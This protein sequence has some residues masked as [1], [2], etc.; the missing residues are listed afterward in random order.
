MVQSISLNDI[1][2]AITGIRKS[3]KRPDCNAIHQYFMMKLVIDLTEDDIANKTSFLLEKNILSS[4]CTS[5]GDSFYLTENVGIVEV[6]ENIVESVDE[7]VE[8]RDI[9]RVNEEYIAGPINSYFT[10]DPNTAESGNM[11][12][13][14][15]FIKAGLLALKTFVTEELYSLSRIMDRIRTE[16]DQSKIPEKNENLRDEISSKDLII[17]MVSESLSQIL[18]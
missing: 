6:F 2:T 8:D 18:L 15:A 1:K 9:T 4:K 16:Y 5:K 3:N 7:N 17:K 12:D 13:N 11:E 10:A 14:I